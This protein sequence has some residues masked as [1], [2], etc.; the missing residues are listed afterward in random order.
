MFE[1]KFFITLSALDI[2]SVHNIIFYEL[3]VFPLGLRASADN[4]PIKT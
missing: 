1:N 3:M 4:L 2:E